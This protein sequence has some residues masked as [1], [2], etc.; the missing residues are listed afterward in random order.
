MTT[1]QQVYRLDLPLHLVQFTLHALTTSKVK[2]SVIF[3]LHNLEHW[4]ILLVAFEERQISQH[5][6]N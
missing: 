5:V 4:I 1:L 3:N 6:G 2:Q